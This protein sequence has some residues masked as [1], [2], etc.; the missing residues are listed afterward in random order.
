MADKPA[1]TIELSDHEDHMIEF[2]DAHGNPTQFTVTKYVKIFHTNP[3]MKDGLLDE[4][5]RISDGGDYV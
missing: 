1:I 3:L 4:L 2:I 5:N